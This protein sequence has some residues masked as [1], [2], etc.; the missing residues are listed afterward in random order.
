MWGIR[1]KDEM[2]TEEHGWEKGR[3]SRG[4]D[5]GD[6]FLRFS[7]IIGVWVGGALVLEFGIEIHR[8]GMARE[9]FCMMEINMIRISQLRRINFCTFDPFH[10][11]QALHTPALTSPHE[12]H[13]INFLSPLSH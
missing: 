11:L 8:K 3:D 6:S 12:H 5:D 7:G 10:S 4:G 9:S 2:D 1:G 13:V